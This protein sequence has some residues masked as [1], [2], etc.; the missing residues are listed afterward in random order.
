MIYTNLD[1]NNM[2]NEIVKHFKNITN[3]NYIKKVINLNYNY[4]LIT[5]KEKQELEKRFLK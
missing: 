1:I 5:L 4:K 2:Y 3:K